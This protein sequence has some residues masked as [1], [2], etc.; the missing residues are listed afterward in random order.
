[1]FF[2][3]VRRLNFVGILR[4]QKIYKKKFVWDVSEIY[5]LY[6]YNIYK[7]FCIFENFCVKKN[8]QMFFILFKF[9]NFLYLG[10]NLRFNNI[11]G[12]CRRNCK[13]F[14]VFIM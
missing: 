9:Y 10:Y 3:R 12:Y 13:F 2:V 7:D 8:Y 4:K 1:M 14:Y 6:M 5:I 11:E